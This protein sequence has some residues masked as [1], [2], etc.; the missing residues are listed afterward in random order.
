MNLADIIMEVF[1]MESA[2]L[3][4]RKL[5]AR[6]K[7]TLASAICAVF[8]RDAVARVEFAARQVL[9]ACSDSG[10]LRLNMQIVRRLA[11]YD[12]IDAVAQRRNI[13]KRL[14]EKEHYAL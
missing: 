3:R 2:L 1:A 11:V 7:A 4:S 6:G 8:L 5:A 13:A 10:A 12:P 14:L 9:G